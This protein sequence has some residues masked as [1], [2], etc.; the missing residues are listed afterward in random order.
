MP[1]IRPAS[2]FAR[3]SSMRRFDGVR[4]RFLVVAS[5]MVAIAMVA[6]ICWSAP[7]LG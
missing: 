3:H 6:V 7:T 1:T 2:P 4:A 5:G